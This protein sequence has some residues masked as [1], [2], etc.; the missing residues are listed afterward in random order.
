MNSE[1]S[2][3]FINQS[4]NLRLGSGKQVNAV[5]VDNAKDQDDDDDDL[6]VVEDNA[7]NEEYLV[8]VWLRSK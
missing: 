4:L 7:P 5:I 8:E 2:N 1:W 3:L 6:F